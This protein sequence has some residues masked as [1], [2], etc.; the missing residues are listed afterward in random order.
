MLDLKDT[1]VSMYKA[2]TWDAF[3]EVNVMKIVS[4]NF[5]QQEFCLQV[6]RFPTVS[7]IIGV[8]NCSL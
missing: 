5:V 3:R 8:L 7:H 2:N 6:Q 4:K 1:A